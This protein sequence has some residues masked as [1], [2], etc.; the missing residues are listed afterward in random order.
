MVFIMWELS[1][2]QYK[3]Q[4]VSLLD[5]SREEESDQETLLSDT[6]NLRKVPQ[7]DP[8]DASE[9]PDPD[10]LDYSLMIDELT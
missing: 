9:D 8:T 5:A 10:R 7:C 4:M 3:Q 6:C 1:G 2:K